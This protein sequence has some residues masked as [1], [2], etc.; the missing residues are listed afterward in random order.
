LTQQVQEAEAKQVKEMIDPADGS[1]AYGAP[2]GDQGNKN[3]D[4]FTATF[5]D[6]RTMVSAT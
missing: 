3:L 1:V 4:S 5:A 2:M 6:P